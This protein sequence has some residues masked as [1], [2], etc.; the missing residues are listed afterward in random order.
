MN[1]VPGPARSLE[2]STNS[3]H[4]LHD[5]CATTSM[6]SHESD[7]IVVESL[8]FKLKDEYGNDAPFPDNCVVR[9]KLSR[10]TY[11]NVLDKP[12]AN[13]LPLFV[14][15]LL[16]GQQDHGIEQLVSIPMTQYCQSFPKIQL[17]Q[18]EKNFGGDGN[19]EMIFDLWSSLQHVVCGTVENFTLSFH[20]TTD[21]GRALKERQFREEISPYLQQYDQLTEELRKTEVEH[22]EIEHQMKDVIRRAYGLHLG[23]YLSTSQL[24]QSEVS[25]I[26]HI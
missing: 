11:D 25:R 20:F 14:N 5:L 26:G 12:I 16:P 4:H 22:N 6:S 17:Q 13:D 24:T 9:C 8:E 23:E 1:C 10:L 15:T 2:P 18:S 19:I 3:R 21:E 7:R